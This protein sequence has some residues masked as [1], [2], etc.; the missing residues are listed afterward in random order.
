MDS[1]ATWFGQLD[2]RY[3]R[4]VKSSKKLECSRIRGALSFSMEIA[5]KR[6]LTHSLHCTLKRSSVT[7]DGSR[8]ADSQGSGGSRVWSF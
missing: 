2:L 8:V 6:Q 3:L 4:K 7:M 5:M 1:G